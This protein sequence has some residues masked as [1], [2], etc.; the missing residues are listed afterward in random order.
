MGG[1]QAKILCLARFHFK[2]SRDKKG[3]QDAIRCQRYFSSFTVPNKQSIR[4][5]PP[6]TKAQS[7]LL[8]WQFLTREDT[9]KEEEEG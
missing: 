2:P 5:L 3:G 7:L 9:G 6:V 8:P 1:G 4:R